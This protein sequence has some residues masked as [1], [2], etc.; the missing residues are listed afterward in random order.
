MSLGRRWRLAAIAG[1]ALS[2]GLQF[3]GEAA[4]HA[5]A[6]P[7]A[8]KGEWIVEIIPDRTAREAEAIFTAEPAFYTPGIARMLLATRR[9]KRAAR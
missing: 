1:L 5:Q 3:T 7:Y 6:K 2:G 8:K 9:A 4:A